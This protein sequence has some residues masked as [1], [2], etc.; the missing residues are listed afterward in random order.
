LAVGAVNLIHS[1]SSIALQ[2]S[3]LHQ[4]RSTTL[5][6]IVAVRIEKLAL[7]THNHRVIS[8]FG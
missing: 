5:T 4:R 7:R 2:T 8:T 6:K 1:H 3:L